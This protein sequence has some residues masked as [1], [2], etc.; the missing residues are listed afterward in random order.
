MEHFGLRPGVARQRPPTPVL[1]IAPG[2]VAFL[3]AWICLRGDLLVK[4][5][6]LVVGDA[7]VLEKTLVPITI[8]NRSLRRVRIVGYEKT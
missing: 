6:L 5:S 7:R 4:P 8:Q 1:L 2:A 3:V